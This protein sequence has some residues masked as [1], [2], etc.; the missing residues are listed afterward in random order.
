METAQ[1]T[2]KD[3]PGWFGA[4]AVMLCSRGSP[5][6]AGRGEKSEYISELVMEGLER[7]G[8][9]ELVLQLNGPQE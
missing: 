2:S 9:R 1:I 5:A 7:R 3:W 4:A 8:G 6:A